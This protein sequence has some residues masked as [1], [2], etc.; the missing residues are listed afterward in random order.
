MKNGY[1]RFLIYFLSGTGNT[2]VAA[3]WMKDFAEKQ[4]LKTDVISIDRIRQPEVSPIEGKT[5]IAFCFPTHGFGV[6]WLMLKFI[7]RFPSMKNTNVVIAN[8]RAGSKFL[9]WNMPGVSGLAQWIPALI[10]LLK[11]FRIKG[12]L[13]LDLPS[14]WISIHP[15]Y[16][17]KAIDFLFLNN[18]RRVSKAMDKILRQRFYIHPLV[19]IFL[20]VDLALAPVMMGYQMY[21]RFLFAKLF[22]ATSKCNSCGLCVENCPANAIRMY[23]SRP[24]WTLNCESCMR[25]ISYCPEKAIQVSHLTAAIV[26]MALL[27]IPFY[28][29]TIGFIYDLS[30]RLIYTADFFIQWGLKL[31]YFTAFY[32]AFYIFMK[33]K[34]FDKLIEYT[35]FTRFWR[36]YQVPGTKFKTFNPG[37]AKK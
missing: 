10:F 24:Y 19:L 7:W 34:W 28:L 29:L 20:P 21:G 35:S 8:S 4:S 9:K 25:C 15:G 30:G 16:G 18:K 3:S 17:R 31:L 27:S 13:P 33:L 23:G 36:G 5:L 6:P 22:F 32:W 12:L 1:D 26:I 14:N 37:K 2:M 11:G